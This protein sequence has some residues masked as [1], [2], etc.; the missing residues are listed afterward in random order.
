EALEA[1]ESLTEAANNPE[2]SSLKKLAKLSKN[3]LI[4]I[5]ANLP[6]ATKLVQECNKLLPEIAQLLGLS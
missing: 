2:D 1:V 3:A 4:G 6:N 5:A